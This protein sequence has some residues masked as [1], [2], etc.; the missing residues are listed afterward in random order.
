MVE[1]VESTIHWS[2][3]NFLKQQQRIPRKGKPRWVSKTGNFLYEWD[4]LHGE[5][6]VYT[7]L[8]KH[9]NILNADGSQSTKRAVKGRTINVQ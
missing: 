2:T 1:F 4:S 9:V 5:V 6:E 7:K 3:S 8:G